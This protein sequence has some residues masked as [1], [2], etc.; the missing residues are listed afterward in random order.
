MRRNFSSDS[1]FAHA[2]PFA[3]LCA[4]SRAFSRLMCGSRPLAEAVTASA[5]IRITGSRYCL[6][7]VFYDTLPDLIH[8]CLG[9]GPKITACLNSWN[10]NPSLQMK[11]WGESTAQ[12]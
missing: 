3:T 4:C 1:L 6:C 8:Q 5:G 2:A 9:K 11:A 7:V 10:H 12:R